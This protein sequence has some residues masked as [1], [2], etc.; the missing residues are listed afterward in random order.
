MFNAKKRAQ[1]LQTEVDRL[2]YLVDQMGLGGV[3]ELDAEATRLG[4]Q[5]AMLRTEHTGLQGQINSARAELV[6]TQGRQELQ[7]VGLYRYHHPAETSVQLKDELARVQ[8]AIKQAVRD[9]TA[10]TATNELHLQQLCRS[11]TEVRFGNV[12]DHAPCL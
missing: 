7:T 9:K 2:R 3:A 8:A 10:I 1:E 4:Q 11:G 6:E 12:Q 5:V